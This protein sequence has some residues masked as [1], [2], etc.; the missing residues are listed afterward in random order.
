MIS[1]PI[2]CSV[3]CQ[4]SDLSLICYRCLVQVAVVIVGAE[5]DQITSSRS[6]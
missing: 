6:M 2:W 4:S 5:S 3:T 1:G